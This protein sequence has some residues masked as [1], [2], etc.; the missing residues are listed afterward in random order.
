VRGTLVPNGGGGWQGEQGGWVPLLLPTQTARLW[1]DQGEGQCWDRLWVQLRVRQLVR[2]PQAR[3]QVHL[4]VG[5]RDGGGVE[6]CSRTWVEQHQAGA[7]Q[8]G[9]EIITRGERGGSGRQ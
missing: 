6:D 9:A 7:E 2:E 4:G 8:V 1:G 5:H 3:A